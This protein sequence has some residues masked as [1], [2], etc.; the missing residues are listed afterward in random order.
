MLF[1]FWMWRCR[2][3]AKGADLCRGY[4]DV[5]TEREGSGELSNDG[6]SRVF[7]MIGPEDWSLRRR[8]VECAALAIG[9]EQVA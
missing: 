5:R 8:R 1:V 6:A 3:G 9:T 7:K 2:R 4:V